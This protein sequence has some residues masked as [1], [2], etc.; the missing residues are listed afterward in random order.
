MRKRR[1]LRTPRGNHIQTRFSGNVTAEPSGL[2]NQITCSGR[3]SSSYNSEQPNKTKLRLKS[4]EKRMKLKKSHSHVALLIFHTAVIITLTVHF[5]NWCK[6]Y[7][8][9]SQ[10]LHSLMRSCQKLSA[11]MK[12]QQAPVVFHTQSLKHDFFK[13]LCKQQN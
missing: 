11:L 6:N 10:S 2:K 9:T 3:N 7:W 4:E 5:T 12:L 13:K 1:Q 8:L